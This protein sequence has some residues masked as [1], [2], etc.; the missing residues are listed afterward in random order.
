MRSNLYWIPGPSTGRLA[1]APRPRGG[2]WLTDEV[3]D[4]QALGIKIVVSLL[5]PDE[6]A[7]LDLAAE[8]KLTADHGIRFISLSIPDRGL[9][10]SHSE[11]AK[12]ADELAESL[13]AGNNVLIHCRQGIG[14]SSIIAAAVLARL[15]QSPDDALSAI[16]ASRGRSVPDTDEQRAWVQDFG[17]GIRKKQAAGH[18]KGRAPR[19]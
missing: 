14:R 1:I 3:H 16:E 5:T 11:V 13:A 4:W 6:I 7:E 12:L 8:D 17:M 9:P 2:D 15:G 18:S 19:T 10:A